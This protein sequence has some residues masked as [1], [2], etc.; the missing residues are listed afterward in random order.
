[1]SLLIIRKFSADDSLSRLTELLHN[2]Y[3]DLGA[4]GMNFTAVDQTDEV[5]A[6][7]IA[8]GECFVAVKNTILVGTITVYLPEAAADHEY[9]RL[10]HVAK[11]GQLA[12][13][14]QQQ[15]AGI[16]SRLLQTAE[17]WARANQFRELALDTAIPAHELL[18]LY[19][20]RGYVIV[21]N[22][23]WPGKTYASVVMAK[24]L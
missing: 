24:V 21:G 1:M 11:A 8:T 14:P 7:R 3:A 20:R 15:R 6:A 10:P 23:Q 17:D 22:A 2:A 16:G 19:T 4:R 9:F 12:V 13:L 5:T 18:A